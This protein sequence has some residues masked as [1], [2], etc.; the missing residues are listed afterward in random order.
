MD[1]L[2]VQR[3]VVKSDFVQLSLNTLL[4]HV[5]LIGQLL[6]RV[7]AQPELF[8]DNAQ[9]NK[10]IQLFWVLQFH[11]F[12]IGKDDINKIIAQPGDC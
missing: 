6:Q 4:A 9:Q 5:Y 11:N 7:A 12:T 8:V 2:I 3:L 1:K 10:R